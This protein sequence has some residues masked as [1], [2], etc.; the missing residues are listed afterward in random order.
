[1]ITRSHLFA[2]KLSKPVLRSHRFKL[3]HG[4]K[5]PDS[6]K[7]RPLHLGRVVA[8]TYAHLVKR[9]LVKVEAQRSPFVKPLIKQPIEPL[10][11]GVFQAQVQL[12]IE[13]LQ[14]PRLKA[15]IEHLIP[16]KPGLRRS[17]PPLALL[18]L[19]DVEVVKHA[20]IPTHP[21]LSPVVVERSV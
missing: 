13:V 10:R 6:T 18:T 12:P 9:K 14:I 8:S 1:M 19:V 20:K 21:A 11:H 4:F 16:D 3:P 17:L 2:F 15:R 5:L 7:Q